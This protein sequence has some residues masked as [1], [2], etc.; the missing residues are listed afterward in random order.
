MLIVA[1]FSYFLKLRFR[2]K[3]A[4]IHT[5][6]FAGLMFFDK[7]NKSPLKIPSKPLKIL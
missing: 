6:M 1:Y 7:Y 5:L 3:K 4:S 2:C